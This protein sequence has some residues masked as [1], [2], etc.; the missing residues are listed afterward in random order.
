ME[1][2]K[3]KKTK[4]NAR[5]RFTLKEHN[6]KFAPLFDDITARVQEVIDEINQEHNY[7]CP[8]CNKEEFVLAEN[9]MS[10]ALCSLG[11]KLMITSR[12]FMQSPID[13]STTVE[14]KAN[15]EA[16]LQ[17]NINTY[18]DWYQQYV[19]NKNEETLH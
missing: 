11:S 17:N 3:K 16:V 15:L 5:S 19:V 9:V 8:A 4:F 6:E 18:N 12:T 13:L 7:G 10:K 14:L 2:M 1:Y